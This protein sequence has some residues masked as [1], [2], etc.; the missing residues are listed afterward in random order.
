V[1]PGLYRASSAIRAHRQSHAFVAIPTGGQLGCERPASKEFY[2]LFQV[3]KMQKDR[4]RDRYEVEKVDKRTGLPIP[5]QI[6]SS[7]IKAEVE[8]RAREL[9][10]ALT[11]EKREEIEFR[12]SEL[13]ASNQILFGI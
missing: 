6:F 9:N 10:A 5:S 2:E 12:C 1:D 3:G 4:T 8:R 7:R 11:T 13:K